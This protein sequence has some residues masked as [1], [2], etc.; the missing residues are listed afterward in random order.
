VDGLVGPV[1]LAT[2]TAMWIV[3]VPAQV[4]AAVPAPVSASVPAPVSASVPAAA[5]SAPLVTRLE[6]V[7]DA[8]QV[9]S[10]T[11][12]RY[13]QDRATVRVFAK[14]AAGWRQV[15]GPW[16]AWIGRSGF[17][18]PDA[19]REGDGKTPTGSYPFSFFFGVDHNPGVRFPWRHASQS[20]FWDDDSTS[21]RYN[22]WVD[23]DQHSAGRNPEPMHI[24]PSY[25]D[26]A[27]IAYNTRHQPGRGSAIFL[28]VTHNSATSGC[29]ALPRS[30]VLTLLRWLN[31][32]DQPR[33]I[34]G[35]AATV[36][37]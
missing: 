35:R 19:K 3:A 20:D 6:G 15:R 33:I 23:A 14:R 22:T 31:P 29:V 32:A 9:I 11:S 8:T 36:T 34:M 26:G 4:S 1:A 2:V 27:V 24:R 21:P 28:H 7:G 25:D 12:S 17:A 5:A 10:V 16:R 13:G 37:R 30:H 18:R